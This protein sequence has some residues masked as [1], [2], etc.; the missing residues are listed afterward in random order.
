MECLPDQ[1][2]EQWLKERVAEDFRVNDPAHRPRYPTFT[3][4]RIFKAA[5]PTLKTLTLLLFYEYD[6]P[7]LSGT[8]SFPH[9]CEL[10]VHASS[11]AHIVQLEP[12]QCPSLRRFHVIHDVS[13]K[14]PM[15]T[16]ITRLMPLLT[17]LKISRL[18]PSLMG[19][20]DVVRSLEYILQQG[21]PTSAGFPSTLER[22]LVQ[23]QD[24]N[25]YGRHEQGVLRVR[26]FSS[27]SRGG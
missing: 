20:A 8:V 24:Q 18:N 23:M 10:V 22:V 3:I 11:T 7:P 26:L 4:L 19:S 12:P 21:D 27:P 9:P 17:H 2:K 1:D 15:T 13:L 25:I 16:T 5:S 14:W 6:E